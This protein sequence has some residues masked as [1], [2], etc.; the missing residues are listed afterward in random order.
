M[1]SIPT[2]DFM[3][4]CAVITNSCSTPVSLGCSCTNRITLL[5]IFTVEY[6]PVNHRFVY[7]RTFSDFHSS[8]FVDQFKNDILLPLSFNFDAC[9][10]WSKISVFRHF[11][12][13]V[14]HT[15]M[16]LQ[17]SVVFFAANCLVF[18][19]LYVDH[20]RRDIILPV[21]NNLLHFFHEV[22]FLCLDNWLY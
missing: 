18:S 5:I 13:L 16:T 3:T 11:I 17:F 6:L 1:K 8:S 22:R 10:L 14:E 21:S 19:F 15:L 12:V 20:F 4:S 2:R 9:Y 7:F